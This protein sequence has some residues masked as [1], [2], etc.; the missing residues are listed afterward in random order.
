MAA[1]L[2]P[3]LRTVA[4]GLVRIA[5]PPRCLGCGAG[6][7][8]L[9]A[10]LCTRC[11]ERLDR[12][13][14]GAL[15]ARLY[16]HDVFALWRF[17]PE[18]TVQRLQHALKYGNRPAYGHRLGR[19]LGHAYAAARAPGPP[20]DVVVPVP[21]HAARLLARGYNQSAALADGMA[22][23]LAV[24]AMPALAR[25]RATR[26]QTRL[27]RAART[28]NVDG[29]FAL[30]A[31]LAARHVLLVDDVLTTGA[32]LRAAAHALAAGGAVKVTLVALAAAGA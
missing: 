27:H 14:A 11:A 19:R 17:D 1:A 8:E 24:S 31:P 13:D 21:L 23:A 7:D 4:D 15:A 30:A 16:E 9:E 6:V 26:T 25:V 10:P 22:E 18:G 12:P 28:A 20:P 2:R 3:F 5:Y 29:A 32:T